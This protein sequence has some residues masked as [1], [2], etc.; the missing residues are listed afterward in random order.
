MVLLFLFFIYRSFTR[1]R[2]NVE[3]AIGHLKMSFRILSTVTGPINCNARSK[4]SKIVQCCCML[5]NFKKR[6]R[7]EYDED[8]D[9]DFFAPLNPNRSKISQLIQI[10]NQEH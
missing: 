5:E 9:H 7:G 4:V 1:A 8:D 3:N 6:E 10:Y 2:A